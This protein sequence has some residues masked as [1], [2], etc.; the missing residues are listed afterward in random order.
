M[1]IV[2]WNSIDLK[3]IGIFAEIKNKATL[4]QHTHLFVQNHLREEIQASA[5]EEFKMKR[6]HGKKTIWKL[7]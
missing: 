1:E 3:L 4:N 7:N 2:A 5:P 6:K